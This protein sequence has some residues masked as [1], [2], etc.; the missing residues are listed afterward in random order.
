VSVSFAEF[1][2]IAI[3]QSGERFP[4][5]VRVGPPYQ[6]NSE[7][8]T[9]RCPVAIYPLHAHLR[10]IAGRDSFQ[11][12]CLASRTALDLL[13]LFVERGGRLTYD[14]ANDVPLDAYIPV[15]TKA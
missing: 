8:D 15:A 11:A 12:V 7:P 9:W 5:R 3:D 2:G 4:F 14:G 1:E 6:S 10:D 13:R